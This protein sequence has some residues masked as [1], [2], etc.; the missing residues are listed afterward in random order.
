MQPRQPAHDAASR[1]AVL[2]ELSKVVSS[3]Q[4]ANSGRLV[5]FLQFV[6]EKTVGGHSE[7]IKEYTIAVEVFGKPESFDPR[8]DTIVRVQGSKLRAKLREYYGGT[9][10]N[11]EVVIDLPR[12][13]YVPVFQAAS[14]TDLAES[15]EPLQP[16]SA[17][18]ARRV[19][20]LIWVAALAVMIAGLAWPLWRFVSRPPLHAA[21]ADVRSVVVLPFTDLSPNRDQDYFCDGMTEEII[22][23][24]SKLKGLRVVASSSAFA[25]KGKR[26]D[27]REIGREL[28]VGAVVEGSVRKDGNRIRVTAELI[29]TKD[30]Y[31]SWS[32]TYDRSLSDVFQVQGDI[33]NSIAGALRVN[34]AAGTSSPTAGQ[35]TTSMEAYTAYLLG[36]HHWYT[37]TEE[38]LKKAALYFNE[39]I[40]LDPGFARGYA[41]LADVY[42]QLDGW[43]HMAPGEAMP[44][45]KEFASKAMAL[46]PSLA[47]PHVSLGAIRLTYDWDMNAAGREY[48]RAIALDPSYATAHWWY[49]AWLDAGGRTQEGTREWARALELE[50]LSVP[51]LVDAAGRDYSIERDE[52]KALAAVRRAIDIDPGNV[53]AHIVLGSMLCAAGKMP[54]GIRALAHAVDLAPDYPAALAELGEARA[55]AGQ[56]SGARQVMGRLQSLARTR[57]VPPFEIARVQAALGETAS[58]LASL[59]AA[60]DERSPQLAWYLAGHDTPWL[61]STDQ[62]FLA[63]VRNALS[64]PPRAK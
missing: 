9:G 27:V 14:K 22:A 8:L 5:S 33:S 10:A 2:R 30:G 47:D 64:L 31:Q 1:D 26:Q 4:F 3:A 46:D 35:R 32:D 62:R 20:R 55:R 34:M 39:A 25:L 56:A 57:Y 43:E 13:S 18:A 16:A 40:R 61:A 41:G 12:G 48:E 53:L 17:P 49:A 6:V 37:R 7:E 23:A 29:S 42:V 60:R 24:L 21:G 58:A 36:R 28:N 50:P 44:K 63:L 52:A 51:I 38:G 15:M 45:A 59:K 54:E 19:S 11:D